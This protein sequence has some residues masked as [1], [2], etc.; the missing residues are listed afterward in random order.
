MSQTKTSYEMTLDTFDRV[1]DLLNLDKSA[2][3]MI[4]NPARVLIVRIPV[5]MDDGN[6]RE[7]KGYRVQHSIARGPSKG[8]IRYHPNVTLDEVKMLATL[9]SWKTSLFDL[10]FGG[11]KGGVVCD[12]KK[13]SLWELER[14]TKRYTHEIISM[15][16][17]D[18]DIPA[19]DVGTDAQVMA[20]IMDAYSMTQGRA[21]PGV[22]TGK[23][24]S[25]GGSLGRREAT[26]RGC[27]F[28]SLEAMKHL[29]MDIKSVRVAIEGFGNVGAIA[30]EL[31]FKKGA[32]IVAV[33]DS[34]GEIYNPKGFDVP[35]LLE[36][37]RNTKSVLGF[38]CSEKLSRGDIFGIDSDLFIPAAL[39]AS[40]NSLN[41]DFV[42]AKVIAEGAN[43][44]LTPEADSILESRG[45]FIIPD[46]LANGGGVVVSYFE[47]SQNLYSFYWTENEVNR[48]LKEKMV[49]AFKDVLALNQKKKVGMRMAACMLAIG[50]LA[51]AATTRGLYP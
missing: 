40:V 21:V 3:V 26:A 13:L 4:K 33:S 36:H 32:T 12:P 10:P 39:E 34:T 9:M 49:N 8:G 6:I 24:V 37:K 29:G 45:K 47:W 23:P 20:W 27:V 35:R 50:R 22:V 14:L 19:P 2:R 46:I 18:K 11:A 43:G 38:T 31:L 44:P 15:I 42:K 41:A 51:E 1:A 7:F 30:A 25:I 28:A 17:P 16:G 48:R 5:R